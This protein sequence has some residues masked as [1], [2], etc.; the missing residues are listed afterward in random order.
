MALTKKH[1]GVMGLLFLSFSLA[2]CGGGGA[3]SSGQGGDS[4]ALQRGESYFLSK[5]YVDLSNIPA[6]LSFKVEIQG[7]IST[8]SVGSRIVLTSSQYSYVDGILTIDLA[9]LKDENGKTIIS[10]SEANI[11]ILADKSVTVPCLFVKKVI[12]T[13]DDL[14]SINK[15]EVSLSAAYILGNDID[16]SSIANWEPLGYTDT[17]DA[18]ATHYNDQFNGVLD[19]NGYAIKNVSTHYNSDPSTNQDIYNGNYTFSDIAHSTGNEFGVFQEIGAAGVVRNVSFSNVS[20]IGR[21]MVGVVA[22]LNSGL[23]ENVYVDKTCSVKESTHFYDET[24]NVA[25]IVGVVG[26]SGTVNHSLSLTSNI[27]VVTKYVDYDDTYIGVPTSTTDPTPWPNNY[28]TFYSGDKAMDD[29]NGV[30]STGVYGGVGMTYGTS[31]NSL[32]IQNS[33]NGVLNFTTSHLEVNKTKDGPD[34]GTVVDC[35]ALSEADLKKKETYATYGFDTSVWNLR[36]D[37]FPTFKAI[38]PVSIY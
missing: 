34:V 24:C 36:D 18:A 11:K 14:A 30:R 3:A 2:A 25:G 13:A 17:D 16:C 38:Y 4:L 5:P 22:G 32:S 19:G 35:A 29:S 1:Y 7:N 10:S 12:K 23:I 33:A 28:W 6:K 15:D 26:T 8:I 21:T 9:A 27:S 31:T 37:A 20:I